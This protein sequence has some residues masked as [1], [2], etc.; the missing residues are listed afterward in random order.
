MCSRAPAARA[1]GHR[2]SV[3]GVSKPSRKRHPGYK[4]GWRRSYRVVE[5]HYPGLGGVPLRETV[6]S[7]APLSPEG[8]MRWRWIVLGVVALCFTA[9]IVLGH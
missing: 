6:S 4:Q 3:A 7:D 1:P 8:Q 5:S 2:G 9:L